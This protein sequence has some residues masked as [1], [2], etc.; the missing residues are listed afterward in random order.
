M[1][2]RPWP[3]GL[4]GWI[5]FSVPR[6]HIALQSPPQTTNFFCQLLGILSFLC[7]RRLLQGASCPLNITTLEL[8]QGQLARACNVV[9]I[10]E[11]F[12]LLWCLE[13]K[14]WP[15]WQPKASC[16]LMQVLLSRTLSVYSPRFNFQF[17]Q[18]NAKC[19][20]VQKKPR[21][22]PHVLAINILWIKFVGKTKKEMPFNFSFVSPF[23]PHSTS[24][25][26]TEQILGQNHK[27]STNAERQ[28]SAFFSP[29]IEENLLKNSCQK[30]CR[31]MTEPPCRATTKLRCHT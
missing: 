4:Q 14:F 18:Q 31:Q 11:G 30:A 2:P 15:L 3:I 20:S 13:L 1:S 10:G 27:V 7:S 19:T 24:E 17:L 6:Q 21:L 8:A 9:K 28:K 29:I 23:F 22:W 16:L 12:L 5:F 25:G 26:K